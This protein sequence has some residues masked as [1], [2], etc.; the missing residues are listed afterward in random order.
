MGSEEVVAE[1]DSA[2]REEVVAEV[3]TA[4]REEIVAEVDTV[5][6]EE[7]AL[8]RGDFMWHISMLGNLP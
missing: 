3:D 8:T 7:V 4:N 2:D 5:D 6:R 1:V